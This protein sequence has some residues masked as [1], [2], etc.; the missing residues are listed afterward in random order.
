MMMMMMMMMMLI[1]IIIIGWYKRSQATYASYALGYEPGV[2]EH[3]KVLFFFFFC[4]EGALTNP[5]IKLVPCAVRI[6]LSLPTVTVK[7]S[8]TSLFVVCQ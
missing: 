2:H 3:K 5:S 8:F 6:F 7:A 1:I 4:Q